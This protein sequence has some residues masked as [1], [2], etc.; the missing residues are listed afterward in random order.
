MTLEG[1]AAI[2]TG[3]S[4]GV[5]AATALRLAEQGCH[6]VVNYSSSS[7]AAELVAGE[8][9]KHGVKVLC[10]QADV[11]D[12]ASVRAMVERAGKE[13]GRLDV[14][15]NNAGT[16]KFIPHDQLDDIVM[17]DFQRIMAVNVMGPLHCA[18]AARSLLSDSGQGVV[19]N[20]GS[21][22]GLRGTGSSIPYCASKAALH[23]LTVTLAR[24]MAPRVRVNAVAPGFITGPWLKAG[25]GEAYDQVKAYQE[26]RAALGRVCDAEDVAAAIMGLVTGSTLVTG[27]V[28]PVEGGSMLAM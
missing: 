25:L 27:Q 26:G 21:I 8:A 6:V 11:S 20:V 16:T 17:E 12:D 1:R 2:V 7:A 19:I 14:L 4:S 18:R 23:N 9:E 22:A 10:V 5:G 3:S 15:V 24:V 13:F 28:L